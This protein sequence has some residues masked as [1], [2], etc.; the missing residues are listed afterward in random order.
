MFEIF[1]YMRRLWD[2]GEVSP[3]CR[4][5]ITTYAAGRGHNLFSADMSHRCQEALNSL[6]EHDLCDENTLPLSEAELGL[7]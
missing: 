2:I 3:Q 5:A 6:Q 1:H 4:Q 7:Q